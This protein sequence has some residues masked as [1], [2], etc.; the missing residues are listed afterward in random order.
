MSRVSAI[1][2]STLVASFALATSVFLVI[3]R[4]RPTPEPVSDTAGDEP[5]SST[6]FEQGGL[7]VEMHVVSPD[8][9]EPREVL[10]DAEPSE[11]RFVVREA[12]DAGRP[13]TGLKPLAW[14]TRHSATEGP[15]DRAQAKALIQGLLSPSPRLSR[16]A[17]TNLNQYFVVTLDDNPSLS[18]ID[19]QLQSSKTKVI[20]MVALASRG[21]DFVLARDRNTVLVT[22]TDLGKVA[23]ADLSKRG[24]RY[25]DVGGRP[26]R[27]ALEPDGR[28][29]WVGDAARSVVSVIDVAAGAT[30]GIVPV[31]EGP[32]EFAFQPDGRFAY[33]ASRGSRTLHVVDTS[34]LKAVREVDVGAGAVA[35]D[36]SPHSRQVYVALEPGTVAVV[37]GDRFTVTGEVTLESGL[38]HLSVSP[39]GRWVLVANRRRNEVTV[40]DA[41]T[42]SRRYTVVAEAAPD[43]IDFTDS[44]AYVRHAGSEMLV[45]VDLS[46]LGQEATPVATTVVMGQRPPTGS[47]S[48]LIARTMVRLPEGNGAMF[49]NSA[50]RNLYSYVEGMTAPMGTYPSYPW[51]ARGILLVDRTMT[52]ISDGVYRAFF[53]APREGEFDVPF[54]SP[55]SPALYGSFSITV[56]PNPKNVLPK[57]TLAIRTVALQQPLLAEIPADVDFQVTDTASGRPVD[58]IQD[59]LVLILQGPTWEE[60]LIA[61]P[62]SDGR[63]RVSLIFP[64][65]GNY[66]AMWSCPSLGIEF[67][68]LP[69]A[70]LSVEEATSISQSEP[71]ERR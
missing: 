62:Q 59:L 60:R 30:A 8:T 5:Y 45:L 38:S 41:A 43:R 58:G 36:Y 46:T 42:Q 26:R 16:S 12:G 71:R 18:I 6:W 40:I 11:I 31:G 3:H 65:P 57:S 44:F 53:Q 51:T 70:V 15:T 27:I 28:L 21:T 33:V 69:S 39:D 68:T 9:G 37:D 29:A 67:T 52:E 2:L 32:H 55:A 61:K 49:L 23:A 50:D 64:G 19:P 56:I 48:T 47:D 66:R 25:L 13:V 34:S 54:I 20:G 4:G 1:V 35:L 7:R 24:A 22:L 63:Y 17:D 10:T 14:L